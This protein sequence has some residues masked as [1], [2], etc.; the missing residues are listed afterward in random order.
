MEIHIN[1]AT[2]TTKIYFY[3]ERI[4]SFEI[5]LHH[6]IWFVISRLVA[7]N[8]QHMVQKSRQADSMVGNYV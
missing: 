3:C 8:M 6:F 4:S 5:I 1:T 2:N 7:E